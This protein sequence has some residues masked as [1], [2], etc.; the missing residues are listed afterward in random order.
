MC[1]IYL[2]DNILN[3]L[4]F[5]SFVPEQLHTIM[6]SVCLRLPIARCLILQ[7]LEAI[8][9][10]SPARKWQAESQLMS[11]EACTTNFARHSWETIWNTVW[12]TVW[13]TM[14]KRS[15]GPSHNVRAMPLSLWEEE[16]RSL[17]AIWTITLLPMIKDGHYH[18]RHKYIYIYI[19][20]Y[21]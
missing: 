5:W 15:H 18:K 9:H 2:I 19:Y 11:T 6:A 1:I 20:I 14:W 21:P 7:G 16:S 12:K 4:E 8:Q 10:T 3:E 17:G 13:N